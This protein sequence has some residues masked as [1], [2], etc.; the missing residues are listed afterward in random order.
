[1]LK[2]VMGTYLQIFKQQCCNFC[3]VMRAYKSLTLFPISTVIKV[4]LVGE[5]IFKHNV[6]KNNI[7]KET[8]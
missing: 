6:K 8:C 5:V 3:L 1:M 2:Q 4:L 7:L